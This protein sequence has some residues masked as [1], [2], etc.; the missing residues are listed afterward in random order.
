METATITRVKLDP[1][2]VKQL[3][4]DETNQVDVCLA[5]YKMVFNDWDNIKSIEDHPRVTRE[6]NLQ[7]FDLFIKFDS[8]HHPGAMRGG[9]WMNSGFGSAELHPEITNLPDWTVTLETAIVHY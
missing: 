8:K 7:L 5:L 3:F 4:E 9:L 2:K 1:E 6:T